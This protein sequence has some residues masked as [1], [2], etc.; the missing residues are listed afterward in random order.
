MSVLRFGLL[1]CVSVLA[2]LGHP[3]AQGRIVVPPG[4]DLQGAI[5]RARSGDIIVLTAGA[6]YVGN[7]TLP[8][9]RNADYI[10]IRSDADPAR[11]PAGQRV[12][13]EHAQ[14]MPVLRSPNTF[15]AL[16]T[17]PGA[18]HWRLQWLM[19]RANVGGI[20]DIITLGDGSTG[21]RDLATVPHHFL[22]DGLLIRGDPTN[23]QKRGIA[24]NSGA[25]TIRNSDIRDIKAVGQDSQAICGW[26]GPGPYL[27]ENN[28][29][30]AAGENVLFGGADPAI[31]GLVPSDIVFRRNFVTKPLSWRGSQWTVKNLFEL[32]SAQRVLVE[33]NVFEHSWAAAQ[34]GY[35]I[36]FTPLNQDGEAPWTV[37][38]DVT[39]QFNVLRHAASGINML[40]Y[41]YHA[42]SRQ[43]RRITIRGNLFYDIDA[44]RWG[45]DGRF[46]LIG[47]EPADIVVDHNTVFQ[48][49]TFLLLYGLR[50]G[51]PRPVANMRIT[52]N[53]S[54]HNEYGIFGEER[55]SGLPAI[56][57][58]LFRPDIRANVLTGGEPARYPPGNFFPSTDTFLGEF[59][60][61]NGGD[62]R[63]RSSS[64][65][66]AAGTDGSMLGANVD[67]LRRG[68]PRG[69][70][71]TTAAGGA[72]Q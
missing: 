54:W 64:R 4:G 50:D 21:Q 11:F 10:T 60:D 34:T 31:H 39:F 9:N 16:S 43:T 48:S 51:R 37:V 44:T 5:D 52:N 61:A 59:V 14:W 69:D 24:L 3:A 27:I 53:L 36:L 1:V 19:F 40:G 33:W 56:D 17:A 20:G 29:L 72:R 49:G 41:D 28:Y 2:C 55:G 68:V 71:P 58:Y 35:A 66:R 7:F 32:K 47:D 30:E 25:T 23:G 67:A 6:T 70:T 15:P 62:Y 22:L 45:G 46:L 26:N 42:P 57:A 18:H 8:A 38:S 12:G 65:F 63:L 13:P